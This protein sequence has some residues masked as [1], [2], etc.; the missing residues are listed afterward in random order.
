MATLDGAKALGIGNDIGD[1]E[2]EEG[3]H[4][5]SKH[6]IPLPTSNPQHILY[7]NILNM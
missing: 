5:P 3:R 6:E 2:G 7:T 4:Y 1:R